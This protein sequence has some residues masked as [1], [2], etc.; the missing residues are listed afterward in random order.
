MGIIGYPTSDII[1][2]DVRV[3][4]SDLLGPLHKEPYPPWIWTAL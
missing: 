3:H 4:K 2:E 1:L